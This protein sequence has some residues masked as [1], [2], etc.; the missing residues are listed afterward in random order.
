MNLTPADLL[1]ELSKTHP[2]PS[3][4][5]DA[6]AAAY[7]QQEMQYLLTEAA[8]ILHD[9]HRELLD[10]IRTDAL[11]SPE[12]RLETPFTPSGT[13]I[14]PSSGRNSPPYSMLSS[15]SKQPTPNGFSAAADSMNLRWLPRASTASARSNT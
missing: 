13:S 8:G 4:D 9:R 3:A 15:T 10:L 12:Y 11:V 6:Y 14:S 1:T 5:A 2:C 7:W